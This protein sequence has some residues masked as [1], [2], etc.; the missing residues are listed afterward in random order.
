MDTKR[1]IHAKRVSELIN[2]YL[3]THST[4]AMEELANLY[5]TTLSYSKQCKDFCS[6]VATHAHMLALHHIEDQYK[7][8]TALGYSIKSNLYYDKYIEEMKNRGESTAGFQA[9]IDQI[10]LIQAYCHYQTNAFQIAVNLL[11][12]TTSPCAMA[13]AGSALVRIAVEQN[14]EMAYPA[15]KLLVKMDENLQPP[16][17]IFEEDI[18]RMAYGNLSMF[19][20]YDIKITSNGKN[21]IPYNI[22]K[23]LEVLY[24][25][26]PLLKDPQQKEWIE[27]DIQKCR[28]KL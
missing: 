8:D 19:Y 17:W 9:W 7:P 14:A 28:A 21:H 6:V 11:L 5:D 20:T 26:A 4:Q 24:R 10:K 23:A 27:E 16:S 3:C 13:L 1:M 15:Y 18:Y 12:D 2:Q 22:P 25:I